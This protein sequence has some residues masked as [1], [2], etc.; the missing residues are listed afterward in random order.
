[1]QISVDSFEMR[2]HLDG[3]KGPSVK[4]QALKDDG[5]KLK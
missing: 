5:S 2:G 4:S 1:M 3:I